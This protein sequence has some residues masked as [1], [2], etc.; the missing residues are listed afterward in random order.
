MPR[1]SFKSRQVQIVEH[2]Q[3]ADLG[4]HAHLFGLGQPE[5]QIRGFF[6]GH[7]AADKERV[8]GKEGDGRIDHHHHDGEDLEQPPLRY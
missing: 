3:V 5:M 4:V 6:G 1:A 7:K 2:A 8:E